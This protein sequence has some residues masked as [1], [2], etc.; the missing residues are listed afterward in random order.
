MHLNKH[1]NELTQSL[2]NTGY[3]PAFPE[4]FLILNETLREGAYKNFRT[5]AAPVYSSDLGV[6]KFLDPSIFYIEHC[7]RAHIK[8]VSDNLLYETLI[9]ISIDKFTALVDAYILFFG[10]YDACRLAITTRFP[11]ISK[12]EDTHSLINLGTI[13]GATGD[14]LSVSILQQA[15]IDSNDMSLSYSALHRLAATL[16]KRFN[17]PTEARKVLLKAKSSYLSENLPADLAIYYNL[18]ALID[19][20][21][22]KPEKDIM[23]D[24]EHATHFAKQA[25]TK[26]KNEDHTLSGRYASQIAINMAQ[27]ELA[28]GH[29][30]T[31][32]YILYENLN[33]CKYTAPDYEAEAHSEYAYVAYLC[34]KYKDSAHSAYISS[35]IY[36]KFG[37]LKALSTSRKIL[38]ASLKKLGKDAQAQK[39]T[40]YINHDILGINILTI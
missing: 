12:L 25:L 39:V 32:L 40:E 13:L 16:L 9:N 22:R 15:T 35:N 14:P 3:S 6:R 8:P 29:R 2:N 23:T 20:K 26:E 33:N 4:R 10:C 17:D 24:L 37:S 19:L 28:R 36:A 11:E 30:D 27:L 18:L 31:A 1:L 34:K 5:V 7:K 38:A 21:E